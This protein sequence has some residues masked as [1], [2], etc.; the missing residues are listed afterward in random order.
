MRLKESD[1]IGLIVLVALIGFIVGGLKSCDY[2]NK[3][4]LACIEKTGD[5]YCGALDKGKSDK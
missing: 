5:R 4:H 2:D 1:W 3:I